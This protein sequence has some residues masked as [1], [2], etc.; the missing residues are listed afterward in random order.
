MQKLIQSEHIMEI[1]DLKTSR[2]IIDKLSK[3]CG[4]DHK[5]HAVNLTGELAN[6]IAAR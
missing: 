3:L 5:I 6:Q 4:Q 1:H 2:E